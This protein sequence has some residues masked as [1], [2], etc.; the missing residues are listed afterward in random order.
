MSSNRSVTVA[1]ARLETRHEDER[2]ITVTG[3]EAWPP[4]I[5]GTGTPTG[6]GVTGLGV[7]DRPDGTSQVTYNGERLYTFAA[8]SP[9]E[10]TGDGD[11][12]EFGS[13][14]FTWH[15]VVV[16]A[17]GASDGATTTPAGTQPSRTTASAG[18][19]D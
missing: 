6:E 16:N 17:S 7:S 14:Q 3:G 11:S 4:L 1:S 8:D 13:Q 10:A 2:G 9:G 12:D 18:T 19:G 15:A 5:A